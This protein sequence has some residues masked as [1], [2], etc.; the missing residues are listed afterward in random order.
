MSKRPNIA[1][2]CAGFGLSN[3]NSHL[4]NYFSAASN[5]FIVNLHESRYFGNIALKEKTFSWQLYSKWEGIGSLYELIIAS[6]AP[7]LEDIYCSLEIREIDAEPLF[8][9]TFESGICFRKPT[10][11]V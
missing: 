1:A 5:K 10:F 6:S 2:A 9:R 7:M 4:S 8:A 11:T 3:C